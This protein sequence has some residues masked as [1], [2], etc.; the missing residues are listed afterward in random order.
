MTIWHANQAL[1]GLF[2]RK[3]TR[4]FQQWLSMPAGLP[5]EPPYAGRALRG[6][7]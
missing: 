3:E 7:Q 2:K 5:L 4:Y 6:R 1:T